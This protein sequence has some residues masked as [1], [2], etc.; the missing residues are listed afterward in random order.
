MRIRG[1]IAVLTGMLTS[2]VLVVGGGGV[3]GAEPLAD[4]SRDKVT[5]DGWQMRV[6]K[7]DENLDR[8][9]NLAS[10]L[11]SREGFVSLKAVADID[12]DGT[13]PVNSG[14]LALGYQIGCQVDVTSGVAIGVA[15]GPNVTIGVTS[16]VGGSATISPTVYLKPG[17]ITDIPFGTKPLAGRH[18]SI[19]SDQVHIKI[20]GCMGPV[21]LRSYA[22]VTISTP[23]ADNS[24][25]VYGDPIYL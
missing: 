6:T 3:A 20:D 11:F 8:Y 19:S 5:D 21:S 18:G 24:L 16:G 7:T 17:T 9:P 2:A 13:A 1:V 22:Q 14:T 12:G 4:K 25:A 10:T 23:T 15:I